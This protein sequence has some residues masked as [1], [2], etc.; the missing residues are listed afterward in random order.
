MGG[1]IGGSWR[2]ANELE[3]P[4]ILRGKGQKEH[5]IAEKPE[6]EMVTEARAQGLTEAGAL[7][8]A[9][10][11]P[12]NRAASIQMVRTSGVATRWRR[13]KNLVDQQFSSSGQH[14]RKAQ[15]LIT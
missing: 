10:F 9:R 8:R 4:Y 11:L 6:E 12:I 14:S 2:A 7:S 15:T 5:H 3:G 1:S 13:R